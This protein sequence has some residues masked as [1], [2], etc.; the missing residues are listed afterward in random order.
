MSLSNPILKF[1]NKDIYCNIFYNIFKDSIRTFIT[2][3]FF[4]SLFSVVLFYNISVHCLVDYL[5]S[6]NVNLLVHLLAFDLMLI[7]L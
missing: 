6:V 5:S 2:F 4:H 7:N 1:C 3:F